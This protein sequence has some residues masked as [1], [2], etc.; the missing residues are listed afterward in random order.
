[1]HEPSTGSEKNGL[2]VHRVLYPVLRLIT[3]YT[4]RL[5]RGSRTRLS[6]GSVLVAES[7]DETTQPTKS[8]VIDEAVTADERNG[9]AAQ[10]WVAVPIVIVVISIVV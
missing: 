5:T 7:T 8:A 1:M 10:Y 2:H 4:S 9:E 6:R 3:A